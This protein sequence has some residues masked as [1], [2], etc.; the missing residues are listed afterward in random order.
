MP[1]TNSEVQTPTSSSNISEKLS[2]FVIVWMCFEILFAC[3]RAYTAVSDIREYAS[4]TEQELAFLKMMPGALLYKAWLGMCSN[5]G[6]ALFSLLSAILILFRQK[7]GLFVAY[8]AIFFTLCSWGDMGW[9]A[10]LKH[11]QVE[12]GPWLIGLFFA[13]GGRILVLAGY[14]FAIKRAIAFFQ[15]RN[16]IV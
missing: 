3:I 7:A 1:E 4:L 6:L 5:T 11:D 10:Y 2:T 14:L 9:S 15:A 13:Y 16:K 12:K 8:V